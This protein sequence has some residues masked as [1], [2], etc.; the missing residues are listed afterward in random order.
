MTES[1]PFTKLQE[2]STALAGLVVVELYARRLVFDAAD[3][4]DGGVARPLMKAAGR[5][6]EARSCP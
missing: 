3:S 2:F 1:A 6:V 5:M 4:R